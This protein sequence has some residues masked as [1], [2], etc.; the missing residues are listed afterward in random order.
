MNRRDLFKASLFAGGVASGLPL[1]AVAAEADPNVCLEPPRKTPIAG[2]VD[3]LVCG[4]GPAG[5]AAALTAARTGAETRLLEVHGCLGGVWTAGL[6]SNI[7][8]ADNKT[9]GLLPE[10]LREVKKTGAQIDGLRYDSEAMKLVLEDMCRKAGV[11]VLL[12][13]RVVSAMK[14]GS[15]ITTAI[16]ENRSGR[17]A[18]RAK[19]FIDT[20]GDG[21]LAALAGCKFDFGHP[22]TGRTQPMSLMALLIG[23]SYKDLHARGLARGNGITSF[24]DG[25]TSNES[26]INI[27]KELQRAGIDPSYT[28]PAIF[29]IRDDLVALM[30]NHEYHM[31]AINAQQVTDATLHA[32][33]EVNHVVDSLRGLGG[34][35]KNVRLVAT[36]EQIG[37]REGRRIRGRYTVT[38]D[39]IQRGARFEDAVCRVTYPVDIHSTEPSTNKKTTSEGMKVKPY[40]IPMRSL[41]AA[42]VDGLMMAGRCISGDFFAH[43][44]YRVTGNAV[45]MGEAA[46]RVAALAAK[47][48]RLPHEIKT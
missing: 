44:S 29:P 43:A 8:D 2:N 40:D 34:V 37:T 25:I 24:G 42:D 12:H 13:T 16:T 18:W 5:V 15:R 6:L 17:Q 36:G 45:P 32:R 9:T 19:C 39:D 46:G 14:D 41:I 4:A 31:S 47:K 27:V 3:V 20:T 35:W 38:K 22:E 33:A 26:K 23:V 10:I 7:V 11:K 21:D 30:V 1:R 28:G 48:N